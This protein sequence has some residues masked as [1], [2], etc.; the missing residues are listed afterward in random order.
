MSL[1]IAFNRNKALNAGRFP[2]RSFMS[3]RFSHF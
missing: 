3:F 1:N 2:L